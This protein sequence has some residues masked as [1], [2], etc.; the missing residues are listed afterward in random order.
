M[1]STPLVSII[2]PVFNGEQYIARAIDSVLQQTYKQLE[3]IIVDD[4]STDGTATMVKKYQASDKRVKYI[5]NKKNSKQ[6]FSR[7]VGLAAATGDYIA[8]Q[9]ADDMADKTRIAKQLDFLQ[10]NKAY[11]LVASDMMVINQDD[12]KISIVR[13][14]T[15]SPQDS[16]LHRQRLFCPSL[17]FKKNIL[18]SLAPPYCRPLPI[19]EDIDLLYRLREQK[20]QCGIIH[21]SLYHYRR[22]GGQTTGF[23][24][25]SLLYGEL[26]RYS[27]YSRQNLARDL[28][29]FHN[30]ELLAARDLPS[31]FIPFLRE[32]KLQ[33]VHK[34][35]IN[36]FVIG[37]YYSLLKTPLVFINNLPLLGRFYITLLHHQPVR[38]IIASVMA[39]P[40]Q[41]LR[42]V[43]CRLTQQ[44]F[45][46]D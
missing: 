36:R 25:L 16:W 18:L 34:V 3:L 1:P 35:F 41:L 26:V 33:H 8:W 37:Q 17:M 20:H 21:Q 14:G 5:K 30:D 42:L 23:H 31:A 27:S 44:R 9:D 15:A 22:A 46:V 38:F 28:L 6:W 7:N 45:F 4:G 2:M 11:D 39:V 29:H 10:K 40:R 13:G 43:Y 12:K 19:G 24:F 32:K